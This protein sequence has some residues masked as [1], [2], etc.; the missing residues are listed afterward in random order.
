ME[1]K[2]IIQQL[3][4]Y[5]KTPELVCN[6]TF[7]KF[8]ES[9][10]D[11]IETRQLHTIL[12]LRTRILKASMTCN[13][14][15]LVGGTYTQRGT[16]CN[17]CQL[18]KDKTDK[19]EIYLTAHANCGND[20]DVKGMTAEQARQLIKDNKDLLPYPVRIE[21]GVNWLHID[22]RNYTDIKVIEFNA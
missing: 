16:R 7:N 6:H 10:W 21:K 9:S 17:L 8:G 22:T 5:F 13:N 20:F 4:Q 12:V 11:F 14:Y 18:V 19:G 3:K 15:H 1:R 2:E